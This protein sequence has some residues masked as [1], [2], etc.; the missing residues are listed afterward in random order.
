MSDT[1][2]LAAL[3]H[4][5][6]IT[7]EMGKGSVDDTCALC[8]TRAE[9]LIA[10]GVTLAPAPLTPEEREMLAAI[11]PYRTPTPP[12][13]LDEG[14]GAFMV[15]HNAGRHDNSCRWSRGGV[16]DPTKDLCTCRLAED[17]AAIQREYATPAPLHTGSCGD[18]CSVCTECLCHFPGAADT[19]LDVDR[20]ELAL[21]RVWTAG[22]VDPAWWVS[23][24]AIAREYAA[25]ESEWPSEG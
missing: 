9:H 15:M 24:A 19:Q 25:H 4:A 13:A 23:A 6:F 22:G 7:H 11:P 17:I 21:E 1:D 18:G 12:D 8:L 2:R 16:F 20:L 14:D 10:A 3:L 5:E